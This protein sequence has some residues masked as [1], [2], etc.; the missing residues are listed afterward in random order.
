MSR[1]TF[2]PEQA[3]VLSL[4]VVFTDKAWREAVD[5]DD[6]KS[7]TEVAQRAAYALKATWYAMLQDPITDAVEFSIER[8]PPSGNRRYR[9]FLALKA[10][11]VQ[12]ATGSWYL[13]ISLKF[14]QADPAV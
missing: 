1:K 6:P 3:H 7:L 10:E 12:S 9:R 4:P 14:E 11:R 8:V 2:T 5:I 13:R